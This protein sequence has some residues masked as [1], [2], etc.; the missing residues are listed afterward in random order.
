MTV[1]PAGLA[2]TISDVHG[3]AGREWLRRF[4][5]LIRDCERRWSLKIALP[6]P[7]LSYNF[8][9]P[10]H[11]QD[12][13]EVVVK[14]GVPNPEL[15]REIEA[16]Q[17]YA[18]R[19]AV[20]LLEADSEQGLLLLE[21]LQPGTLLSLLTDDE[22]SASIAASVMRQLWRP[23]PA[24]HHFITVNDWAAGLHRLRLRFGGTTGPL[25]PN[26][27][28]RAEAI[29]AELLDSMADPVILHGDLHHDNILAGQRQPWLA[30]DPKGVIGEPAYEVGALLRNPMPQLL[31][32]PNLE[33]VLARRADQLSHELELDRERIVGW[34]Y[35]QAVLSAWWSL[36]D[37][38]SGWEP[39][40]A[41]ADVLAQL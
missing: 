27:V 29:F 34:G 40:I 37:H 33:Q 17:F 32:V 39:A 18:G 28:A 38:G 35:A 8:V 23:P 36:E 12:G 14:L 19:G 31:K 2:R 21:R 10:A 13:T 30:I 4:H 1:I 7:Q 26:L 11:R 16:L 5:S 22:E 25:P 15:T 3:D 20:Q 9:A 24:R 41:C 6:F